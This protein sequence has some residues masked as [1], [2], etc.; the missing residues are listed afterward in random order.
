[1]I[2]SNKIQGFTLL[3]LMI[4]LAV[5]AIMMSI[6]LPSF[7][8]LIRDSRMTT[9]ANII[10]TSINYARSEAVTRNV[11]VTI[12]R[13]GGG[14]SEWEGGWNIF[15]DFNGNGICDDGCDATNLGEDEL[16]KTYDGVEKGYTLRTG[17]NYP[18]WMA[19]LPSGMSEGSG[20][21]VNDTFRLCDPDADTI[22]SRAININVL[23]RARISRGTALC[24]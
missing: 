1:M 7:M 22:N 3:E 11:Q 24:P 6:A 4:T 10:L 21:N 20:P 16:L 18:T 13:Q 19:Y 2:K 15:T 12:L 8:G 17:G 14:V 5:A 9:D 23:G